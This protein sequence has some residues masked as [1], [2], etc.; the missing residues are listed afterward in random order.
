MPRIE[1][2]KK[3]KSKSKGRSRVVYVGTPAIYMVDRSAIVVWAKQPFIDWL[4]ALPI[5][6][7]T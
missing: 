7:R 3:A 4:N 2:E 6:I 5:M 1:T